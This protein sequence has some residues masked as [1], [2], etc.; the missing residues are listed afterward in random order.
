MPVTSATVLGSV[1]VPFLG[2]SN[3]PSSVQTPPGTVLAAASN[4]PMPPAILNNDPNELPRISGP[5]GLMDNS[6]GPGAGVP[7]N[8]AG[9]GG[10]VGSSEPDN[11]P[12]PGLVPPHH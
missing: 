9:Q 5:A 7:H 12:P 1:N 3:A 8:D 11:R 2:G 6:G 10:S 4:L